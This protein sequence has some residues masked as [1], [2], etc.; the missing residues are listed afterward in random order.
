M[1][2]SPLRPTPLPWDAKHVALTESEEEYDGRDQ[3]HG[4]IEHISWRAQSPQ[5]ALNDLDL[6]S[7]GH[8]A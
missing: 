1:C 8:A 7:I 2:G 3:N 4:G 6:Q 5:K